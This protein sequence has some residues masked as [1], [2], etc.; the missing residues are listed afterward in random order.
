MLDNT[1][2]RAQEKATLAYTQESHENSKLEATVQRTCAGPVLAAS[3][4]VSS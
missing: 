2:R 4:S 1:N 3:V